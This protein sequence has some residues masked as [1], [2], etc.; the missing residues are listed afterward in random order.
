MSFSIRDTV[1]H[2][3]VGYMFKLTA[4]GN[5]VDESCEVNIA[6]VLI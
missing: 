4:F 1:L 5:S 3:I 6:D 2:Y